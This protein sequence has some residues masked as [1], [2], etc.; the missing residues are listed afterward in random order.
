MSGYWVHYMGPLTSITQ[1]LDQ[2]TMH[3][4]SVKMCQRCVCFDICSY[5]IGIS[6]QCGGNSKHSDSAVGIVHIM[7]ALR[8]LQRHLTEL[9]FGMAGWS[10]P[11]GSQQLKIEI[12]PTQMIQKSNFWSFARYSTVDI[13]D[14]PR[15]ALMMP[16]DMLQM[17][18]QTCPR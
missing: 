5:L 14:G 8:T 16:Q 11:L 4:L 18:S 12:H 10:K 17:M 15:H 7:K 2:I 6:Q 13:L 3:H 9:V 1:S